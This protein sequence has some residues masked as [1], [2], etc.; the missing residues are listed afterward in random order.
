MNRNVVPAFYRYLQAQEE[1]VCSTRGR[2][3]KG[4]PPPPVL[5]P[6]LRDAY[7]RC[8]GGGPTAPDKQVDGAKGF[9]DAIEGVVALFKRAEDEGYTTCGLWNACGSLSYADV[10]IAPCKFP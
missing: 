9:V 4:P 7:A 2:G 5:S 10:M 6:V 1:G 3:R 8:G